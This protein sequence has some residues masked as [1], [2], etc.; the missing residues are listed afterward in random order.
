MAKY[1][2]HSPRFKLHN[3]IYVSYESKLAATDAAIKFSFKGRR[4]HWF[5]KQFIAYDE[6]NHIL[7]APS[8]FLYNRDLLD[9]R[10]EPK[11]K[12]T[13]KMIRTYWK[14]KHEMT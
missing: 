14:K 8:T 9:L 11:D 7:A 3:M 10:V 12:I 1:M 13:D 4:E 5:P 6:D 2:V